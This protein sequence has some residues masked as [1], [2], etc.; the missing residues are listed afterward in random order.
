MTDDIV[1][2]P[3][4]TDADLAAWTRVRRILLPDEPITTI[5]QLS[6]ADAP[7]RLILLAEDGRGRIGVIGVAL[8]SRLKHNA[9]AVGKNLRV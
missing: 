7:D 3:A 8:A 9:I 1:I 4:E 6:E 2:R 5:E